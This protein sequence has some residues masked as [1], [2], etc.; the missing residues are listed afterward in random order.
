[1]N[2]STGHRLGLS[3]PLMYYSIQNCM[4][5]LLWMLTPCEP[6]G[7]GL[8][9]PGR[10][11]SSQGARATCSFAERDHTCG[12]RTGKTKTVKPHTHARARGRRKR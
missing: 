10:R 7:V 4:P 8:E 12:K 11:S 2:R 9:S 1:L 5:H 6:N 3:A